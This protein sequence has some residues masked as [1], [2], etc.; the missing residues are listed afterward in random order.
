MGRWGVCGDGSRRRTF[1]LT[2]RITTRRD[3]DPG[4]R[5]GFE[6]LPVAETI[7]A[8]STAVTLSGILSVRARYSEL[9]IGGT[10]RC[11]RWTQK[12]E[13]PPTL[14]SP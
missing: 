5:P 8:W 7:I 2:T 12:P 6:R 13:P 3:K 11:R 4:T 10:V 9:K 1:A 14:L